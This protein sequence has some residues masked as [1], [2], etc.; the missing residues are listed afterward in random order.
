V[1]AYHKAHGIVKQSQLLP[2]YKALCTG[3]PNKPSKNGLNDLMA[4]AWRTG[5]AP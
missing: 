4:F 5:L 1:G 2:Y 3:Q